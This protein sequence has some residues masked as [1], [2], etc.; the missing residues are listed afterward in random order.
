MPSNSELITWSKSLMCGIKLIDD[1]HK[2]LVDLV[3]DMFCHVTGDDEQERKYLSKVIEEAV[4]YIKVH[5]VTEEKIMDAT[6]YQG[7]AE[8]KAEHKKFI[9]TVLEHVDKFKTGKRVPLMSFSKFLK[10]WVLSH[11]AVVD[12]QYFDHFIKVA[13]RNADG[14][15]SINSADA[16]KEEVLYSSAT[17]GI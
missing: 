10:D 13:T 15:L 4:N 7:Y 17:G 9:L 6:K 3:N 1:Q 11:I 12:K 2:G 8:H 14:S 5:F 16:E